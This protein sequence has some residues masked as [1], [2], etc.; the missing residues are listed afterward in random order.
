[1][2][3]RLSRL[4]LRAILILV[5][6]ASKGITLVFKN[7]PLQN[8]DVSSTFDSVE[9]IRGYLQQEIEGQLREMFREDLP[10]IIHRLSQQWLG[11]SG[12]QGKVEM[13]YRDG[14]GDAPSSA[15]AVGTPSVAGIDDELDPNDPYAEREIFPPHP[16]S[17]A[18]QGINITTPNLT[19]RRRAMQQAQAARQRRP[20]N[21]VS[22]S[23][24][25]Y[26]VFP[27]IED[28]DPTY[29][30]RP[31]G[32][33]THS[34]YEAFGRLW[35]KARQGEGRGLGS[36]MQTRVEEEDQHTGDVSDEEWNEADDDVDVIVDHVE[37]HEAPRPIHPQAAPRRPSR[38]PSHYTSMTADE[39]AVEWETFPAVG[40]GVVTRPRVFHSQSQIRAPSESGAMPSP[41]TGSVTARAS[42]GGASSTVGVSTVI[43]VG[44]I[45]SSADTDEELEAIPVHPTNV[46]IIIPRSR[47]SWTWPFIIAPNGHFPIRRLY[48]STSR[49]TL[50]GSH[51]TLQIAQH[52]PKSLCTT[53]RYRI[54]K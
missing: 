31:E 6:S 43:C 3:I 5:V 16:S 52:G 27:D 21:A 12:T 32:V 2:T 20:S 22:E 11:G 42:S 45:G 46:S 15:S 29:G 14:G 7:D 38:A 33:P 41:G 50:R 39:E 26:T 37:Q 8:V 9:V 25:S 4:N 51:T 10:G 30:L 54:R 28:Y 40:G 47:S 19:P 49:H 48:P 13:P 17:S 35:E 24:T 36:L 44:P 34:G 53:D 18:S 23:P 1:M